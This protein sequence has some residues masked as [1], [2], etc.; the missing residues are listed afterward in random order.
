MKIILLLIGHFMGD[1]LFQ[2]NT[3]AREKQINT[4]FFLLH[5]LIYS[6]CL[7]PFCALY[8]AVGEIALTF[9]IIA[10][11][12]GVIDGIKIAIHRDRSI[13]LYLLDQLLHIIVIFL[14]GYQISSPNLLGSYINQFLLQQIPQIPP[15]K[16][17]AALLCYLICSTPAG[18][19]IRFVLSKVHITK[20]ADNAESG[21]YQEFEVEPADKKLDNGFLIGV[22]ERFCILTLAILGQFTAISF[23]IAAKSL[24]RIKKLEDEDFA[25]KYLVGTFLSVLIAVG[26]GCMFSLLT[27]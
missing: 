10:F 20:K 22:L 11:S 3:I 2:N 17:G 8:G 26:C 4:T 9:V 24:A 25:E 6:I 1:F 16:I 15:L 12:H 19:T 13:T 14:I 5:C 27:T 23:V 21:D 7:L 18:V